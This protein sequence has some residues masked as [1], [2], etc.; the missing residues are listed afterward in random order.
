MSQYYRGKRKKNIYDPNSNTPYRLSRTR[1]SLFLDCPLCFYI[2]RRLG[3]DRPP[4]F[5]FNLNSA[6]DKLLKKNSISIV[7]IKPCTP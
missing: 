4:G 3:V 5:P 6:V 7:S 1:L 2:D